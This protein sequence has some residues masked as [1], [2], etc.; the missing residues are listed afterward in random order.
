MFRLL[1]HIATGFSTLLFVAALVLWFCGRNSRVY[2]SVTVRRSTV[3]VDSDRGEFTVKFLTKRRPPLQPS[4]PQHAINR[5]VDANMHAQNDVDA[6]VQFVSLRAAQRFQ[7]VLNA[8]EDVEMAE[9]LPDLSRFALIGAPAWFVA[10]LTGG[11]PAWWLLR[12]VRRSSR[13][14][15]GC[16]RRCGYDLRAS[17]ERCSECGTSIT[18]NAGTP[19]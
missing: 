10:S 3:A 1:F 11:L 9:S 12:A 5:T 7:I 14:A 8:M 16:C 2:G 6:A 19:A 18:P 15:P 13:R 4:A 17:P